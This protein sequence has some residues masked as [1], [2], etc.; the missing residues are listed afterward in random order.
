MS[1]CARCKLEVDFGLS[2]EL[3]DL[4]FKQADFFGMESL[5]EDE[6][7]LVNGDICVYCAELSDIDLEDAINRAHK[8][9]EYIGIRVDQGDLV[10]WL[11]KAEDVINLLGESKYDVAIVRSHEIHSTLINVV[12]LDKV[13]K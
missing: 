8:H 2:K 1:N 13:I 7:A 3:G 6:Q 5:T 4:L 12:D 11:H 9:P 10:T